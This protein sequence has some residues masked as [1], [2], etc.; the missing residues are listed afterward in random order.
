LS[1]SDAQTTWDER[2]SSYVNI[3]GD[4]GLCTQY[5]GAG[6]ASFCSAWKE[7]DPAV[8]L[9][10]DVYSERDVSWYG[11]DY[12]GYAIPNL[13]PVDKLTQVNT[14][15][16]YTCDT[17]ATT[18]T[19]IT[20]HE[21]DAC[22]DDE[23][24]GGTAGQSLYCTGPT[25]DSDYRLGYVA[26]SCEGM[27]YGADCHVG[28]CANTGS[29][30]VDDDACGVDGGECLKGIRYTVSTTVC[31]STADCS[32]GESCLGGFCATNAGDANISDDTSEAGLPIGQS[33]YPSVKYQTGTCLYDQC[34]IAPNGSTF[35][36]NNSEPKVCRGYPEQNSPFPNSVVTQ[37]QDPSDLTATIDPD[38][39]TDEQKDARPVSYVQN[40]ENVQSCALGEDC[41]CTYKKVT[42]IDGSTT[43]YF[44]D[45]TEYSITTNGLC[46]GGNVGASCTAIGKDTSC[47]SATGADDGYCA[48]AKQIDDVL[49]LQGY[50]L[51]R[52]SS[53]NILGDRDLN[54]CI[55]W[56][57]VDQLAG[58]TDL[59]A[60]YTDAGYFD[61]ASYCSYTSEYSDRYTTDG[62]YCSERDSDPGDASNMNQCIH[63][64]FICPYGTYAIVGPYWGAESDEASGTYTE[65]CKATDAGDHDCPFV[66]VPYFSF[67]ESGDSCEISDVLDRADVDTSGSKTVY[68]TVTVGTDSQTYDVHAYYF[69]GAQTFDNLVNDVKTCQTYGILDSTATSTIRDAHYTTDGGEYSSTSGMSNSTW[70]DCGGAQSC[71]WYLK[72]GAGPKSNE[73][74]AC[75]D[76]VQV[77]SSDE[78]NE[79]APYTDRLLNT[80]NTSTFDNL[81]SSYADSADFAYNNAT[82]PTPF[83][84]LQGTYSVETASDGTIDYRP[85]ALAHCS[86]ETGSVYSPYEITSSPDLAANVFSCPSGTVEG[87]HSD[88]ASPEGRSLVGFDNAGDYYDV[89][90]GG[91]ATSNSSKGLLEQLFARSLS[92]WRYNDGLYDVTTGTF[93]AADPEMG[94]SEKVADFVAGTTDPLG[95]DLSWDERVT[96]TPPSVYA[97]DMNN[98]YNDDCEE[99][100]DH[101]LTLNDQNEGDVESDVFYRAYLKFYA[102]ADKNQ[103]PIRRV[104]VDWGDKTDNTDQ[105]GSTSED[106]FYKN[107]RGLQNGTETSICET[108]P[109]DTDYEWGMNDLSC[110]PNYFTYNHVYT[111]NPAGL[112][113]CSYGA[114]GN[115]TNSPCTPDNG[116]SCTY[117]PRVHVRDNWGWCSGTCTADGAAHDADN[118]GDGCYANSG[119]GLDGSGINSQ[120]SECAYQYYTIP[121]TATDPWAYYDGNITVTP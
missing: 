92:L 33:F 79:G 99:D 71:G 94:E 53:T 119:Y 83:G 37:W 51:E 115:V 14:A 50:C 23:Q 91:A 19:I 26:G 82:T 113:D 75:R 31:A 106:N 118:G 78:K 114:D 34:V 98:C 21:G 64:N 32:T 42:Y 29:A 89:T 7:N 52:D 47:D 10:T 30:C 97:V 63:E 27:D 4:I 40:F 54:A 45:A 81:S 66:C 93:S 72:S 103:L 56:L 17:S 55:S 104:I 86:T 84:R 24:C 96:G 15:F 117:R 58:S 36:E 88:I 3:C 5:S 35:D 6:D 43:R 95:T 67:N 22:I 62:I 59:Y 38:N 65:D 110:D 87:V 105:F 74:L 48:A 41:S 80:S 2:T 61:D 20:A 46:T 100:T 76:A 13:L 39:V 69:S 25:G 12:S 28:Y 90:T 120:Y 49:G 11:E 101:S 16:P 70:W 112:L 44:D 1:C 77:T 68:P 18:S 116:N 107:H 121:G 73:Y 108:D 111:C 85:T 9:E 57:P 60:K 8:V 109:T 102:A